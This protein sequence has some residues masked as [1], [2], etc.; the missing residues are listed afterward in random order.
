MSLENRFSQAFILLTSFILIAGTT[1][2][3][4]ITPLDEPYSMDFVGEASDSARMVNLTDN[5]ESVTAEDISEGFDFTY[6]YNASGGQEATMQHLS[7]GY[8]YADINP[9]TDRGKILNYT[10]QETSGTEDEFYSTETVQFGNY[11]VELL[12]DTST[13][14]PPGETV[15]VRVNVTDEWNDEP[16]EGATVELYFTNG[17]TTHSIQELGNQ[18]G[19][20]YYNSLVNV[21]DVYD[22]NYLMQINVTNTGDSIQNSESSY[23]I[24][25]ET[26]PQMA[27]IIEELEASGG[28]NNASFFTECEREAEI[29]TSYNVTGDT[30]NSVNLTL[31]LWNRSNSTWQNF[32]VKEMEQNNDLYEADLTLPDL[33][34]TAFGEDVQLVYNA[35]G[36]DVDAV[37]KRN[38]TIRNFNIRFGASSSAQQ[39]GDYNLEIG[40]EKYFSAQSLDTDRIDANITVKNSTDNLTD[41][42]LTDMEYENGVF[43]RNIDIGSDW[44]EGTYTVHV[45]AENIYGEVKSNQDNFFVKDVNRTF[46]ISGDI[47]ETIITGRTYSYNFTVEN[48]GSSLLELEPNATGELEDV[49]WVNGTSNVFVPGDSTVNVTAEF[50]MSEVVERDGEIVLSD[51]AYND[52]IEVDLDLPDC[53]YRN[54]S[55]CAE[56]TMDLNSSTD[57]AEDIERSF[58]VY[59]LADENETSEVEPSID[60]NISEIS[61]ISPETV[62]LNSSNNEQWFDLNYTVSGPGYFTGTISMADLDI[63]IHL[64]SDAESQELEITVPSSLDLGEVTSSDS[65]TEEIEI[66]NTGGTTVEALD[67]SS[68]ELD[69]SGNSETIS[70]GSSETVSLEL[71]DI[72]SGAS[73]TVTASN[74]DQ[75]TTEIIDVTA[76]VIID[77]ADRASELRER[78]NSVQATVS[79]DENMNTLNTAFTNVTEVQTAYQAG[80]YDRAERIYEATEQKVSEVERNAGASSN[81]GTGPGTP[82]P[83]TTSSSSD[84]SILIILAA[85][86]FILLLI[87]FIAYTSLIPEEG[88]PLY[89]VLGR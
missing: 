3:Y 11:S 52:S 19:S 82:S 18:E 6:T 69:V 59:Y 13:T 5:G 17:T 20:E 74:S 41:F 76:D 63:P 79:S 33:N 65:V 70:P 23:S 36:D 34:T 12:S 45:D 49:T 26:D 87:G 40:F 84:S 80:N 48:L 66:E 60:G 37:Q 51:N 73:L 15:N 39:G 8:W 56:M 1:S 2:A 61:A 53:D 25:V 67:F 89:K 10:L 55:I 32:T 46:N 77:Y 81:S 27:G 31:N 57:E 4:K 75:E 86:V 7:E 58:R 71:S 62:E 16:E 83:S 9:E 38:I 54:G 78:I 21:P 29:S 72:S 44:K 42:D 43:Q 22:A 88:D 35:S 68:E 14:L 24:P 50:N 30:P 47:E 85:V 64:Q 28:C